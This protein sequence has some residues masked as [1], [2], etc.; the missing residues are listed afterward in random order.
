MSKHFKH[1][2][3]DEFSQ[4]CMTAFAAV[5]EPAVIIHWLPCPNECIEGE[6]QIADFTDEGMERVD[7][8]LGPVRQ[9]FICEGRGWVCS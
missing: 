9:C 6:V 3:L 5:V 8:Q 2:T 1:Q 4:S 7:A